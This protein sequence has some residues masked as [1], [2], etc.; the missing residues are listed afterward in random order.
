MHLVILGGGLAGLSALTTLARHRS[1]NY[2]L[3]I[4]LVEP[5]TYLE[6]R[7]ASIRA[8]FDKEV[9]KSATIPLSQILSPYRHSVR[10]ECAK[11]T[12]VQPNL[13]QLN[14]GNEIEYDVCLVTTGAAASEAIL[15]PHLSTVSSDDTKLASIE[16]RRAE[17]AAYGSSLTAAHSV[18]V[19]GGGPIGAELAADVA[20]YTRRAGRQPQVTLVHA[21]ATLVPA[22]TGR[23]GIT[24]RQRLRNLTVNVATS[25][26]ARRNV[27][28]NTWHLEDSDIPLPSDA[29][30]LATGVSPAAPMLFPED[31]QSVRD[32]WVRPDGFARVPGYSGRVFAYGDCC[33]ME[34]KS[35]VAVL[36][37]R[38]IVAN[39]IRVTLDL[40]HTTG[41][42]AITDTKLKRMLPI[43]QLAIVTTG[44]DSGV[45]S[46]PLGTTTLFLPWLK[47]KTMFLFKARG[48]IGF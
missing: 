3:K 41:K 29:T 11:A 35:G 20:A 40:L 4:T 13:V 8:M 26:R 17:L 18:L 37:N 12:S 47:N 5:K 31:A 14:N 24:L 45:A 39:N 32:G 46:T 44:P 15:N 43:K 10:H 48:E 23:C 21:G 7:W 30:F 38:K 34:P 9:C 6:V 16:E 1:K 42:G 27:D 33:D 36:A 28:K 2:D 22:F 19:V 25:Q